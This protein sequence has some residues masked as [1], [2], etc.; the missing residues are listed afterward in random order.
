MKEHDDLD[1]A[2]GI[3]N[4]LLLVLTLAVGIFLFVAFVTN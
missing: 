3:K 2:I 4:G 1:C